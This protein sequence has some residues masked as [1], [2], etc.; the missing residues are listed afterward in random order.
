[1][2]NKYAL[3]LFI[4]LTSCD[5]IDYHPYDGRVSE[6]EDKTSMQPIL[7]RSKKL[8]QIKILSV[9]FLPAIHS[10]GMMKQMIS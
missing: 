10:A 9:L 1:M 3:L 4:L 5:L 2:R 7:S 6:K 8:V